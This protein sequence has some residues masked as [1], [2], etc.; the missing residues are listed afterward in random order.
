M[1]TFDRHSAGGLDVTEAINLFFKGV[2]LFP[3]F[4][5]AIY[6]GT[7]MVKHVIFHGI[8]VMNAPTEEQRKNLQDRDHCI[9][10]ANCQNQSEATESAP[11]PTL[12][13]PEGV[14][15]SAIDLLTRSPYTLQKNPDGSAYYSV[16][17]KDFMRRNCDE[18]LSPSLGRV[19]YQCDFN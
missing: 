5:F 15:P 8:P 6:T 9:G 4:V 13:K 7:S 17:Q 14:D 16:D 2:L 12:P 10:I 3:I 19:I 18:V 1:I 11:R